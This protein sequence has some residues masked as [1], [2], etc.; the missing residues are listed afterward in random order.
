VPLGPR[1]RLATTKASAVLPNHVYDTRLLSMAM[2]HISWS[3][4]AVCTVPGVYVCAC[5]YRHV[6]VFVCV[7][8]CARNR[9]PSGWHNKKQGRTHTQRTHATHTSHYI[10]THTTRTTTES[11]GSGAQSRACLLAVGTK[12]GTLALWRCDMASSTVEAPTSLA[13]AAAA[14]GG[15]GGAI[16]DGNRSGG[17][18]SSGAATTPGV[19]GQQAQAQRQLQQRWQQESR[20]SYQGM[21]QVCVC[22]VML[23]ALCIVLGRM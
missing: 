2:L 9:H 16:G 10:C 4:L 13:A 1:T 6:C 15:A 21:L 7:C 8:A 3:P 12:L 19:S 22:V 23:S 18:E 5:F 14:G 17:R 11:G 20:F